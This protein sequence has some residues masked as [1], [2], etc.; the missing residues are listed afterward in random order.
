MTVS[1]KRRAVGLILAILA[2]VGVRPGLLAEESGNAARLR[3]KYV[4]LTEQLSHNPFQRQLYL[5]STETES[6]LTG[7]IYAVVD[8]PFASINGTLNDPAQAPPTGA[9]CLFCT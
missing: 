1:G 8:Y 5:K 9:T 7:D 3:D 4:S 2:L 6:T